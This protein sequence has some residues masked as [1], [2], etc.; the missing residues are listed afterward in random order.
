MPSIRGCLIFCWER[1]Q[2][3]SSVFS[4]GQKEKI[5][6]CL[7]QR[8]EDIKVQ[9]S[10]NKTI[11]IIYVPHHFKQYKSLHTLNSIYLPW[12]LSLQLAIIIISEIPP[13]SRERSFLTHLGNDSNPALGVKDSS[14]RYLFT[15]L[16][17][18]FRYPW[19]TAEARSHWGPPWPSSVSPVVQGQ[20]EMFLSLIIK[21]TFSSGK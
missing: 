8:Y 20:D 11:L 3:V 9:Q 21:T 2:T 13:E 12:P 19:M 4:T 7:S 18:I 15:I 1:E 6:V 5:D 17:L 16:Y 10:E 14:H